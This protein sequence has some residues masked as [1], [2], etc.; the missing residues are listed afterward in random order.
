MGQSLDRFL[1]RRLSKRSVLLAIAI[2]S[3]MSTT[4]Q[5]LTPAAP[6]SAH[7]DP[8]SIA[9]RGIFFPGDE[10]QRSFIAAYLGHGRQLFDP[11]NY[12]QPQAPGN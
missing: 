11:A 7:P 12:S 10:E 4:Q 8:L 6:V 5:A 1:A 3:V 9:R 2:A